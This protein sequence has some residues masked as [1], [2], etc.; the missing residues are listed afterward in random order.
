MKKAGNDL[1]VMWM[2]A[3]VQYFS[4]TLL[5]H[6]TFFLIVCAV[7]GGGNTQ[8]N[9]QGSGNTCSGV[10][11]SL[12][13]V[14]NG[15]GCQPG[16]LTPC[17]YDSA[18]QTDESRCFLCDADDLLNVTDSTSYCADCQ[19][20]LYDCGTCVNATATT[21]R[22]DMITCLSSM[23]DANATCRAGCSQRCVSSDLVAQALFAP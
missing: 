3:I 21:T 10:E 1:F 20:C 7:L 15:C 12:T 22:T 18:L 5:Q 16:R 9:G 11:V 6:S 2:L 13:A 19:A 14:P 4:L 23:D 17:T 8:G